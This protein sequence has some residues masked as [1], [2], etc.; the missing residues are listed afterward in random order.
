MII[1]LILLFIIILIL[2]NKKVKFTIDFSIIGFEYHFC[3]NIHYFW[4][5]ATLYKEDILKQK[6]KIKKYK[7]TKMQD[8]KWILDFIAV[9]RIVLDM[10]IGLQDVFVT[11]MVIPLISTILAILIQKFCPEST[12][13]FSVKPV[14]NK[15][16]FSTK[17][18]VYF[19]IKLKDILYCIFKLAIEKKKAEKKR[20]EKIE[21][22]VKNG[23]VTA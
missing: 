10:K 4:D 22:A 23:I 9:N 17:G 11:S 7:T 20:K 19:S 14:Y 16:F 15:F 6:E 8:N 1:F 21:K 12:K 3:I 5:I 18:A 2:L 13:Q